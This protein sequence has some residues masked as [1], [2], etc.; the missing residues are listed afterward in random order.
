MSR[1]RQYEYEPGKEYGWLTVLG[2]APRDRFGHRMYQVRCRCG[3]EYPVQG[4]FL[5]KPEPK[6]S[7]CHLALPHNGRKLLSKPGDVI[8]GWT[9]LEEAGKNSHGAIL[10]KCRCSKCGG[11]SFHTRGDLTVRKGKGCQNCKP[12][13]HFRFRDG[14]AI[15]TL[16]SGVEFIVDAALAPRVSEFYWNI[17]SSKG[18]IHRTN[19]GM[20]KMMLHWFALGLDAGH[21][22]IIDHINRN[23]LDCRSENLRIVTSQQNAMNKSL[24]KNNTTGFVGVCFDNSKQNYIASIGFNDKKIYLGRS[25]DPVICAQRYN[26]ASELLFGEYAGH[27]NDVPEAD[28]EIKKYIYEKL[29]PYIASAIIARQPAVM[30]VTA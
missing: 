19:T 28:S 3:K 12:D 15:G 8:N 23:K 10:Y 11:V 2:E 29:S 14:A 9:I 5:R 6:C 22:E 26:Y 7:D 27:K 4:Q 13:Y 18:Y 16:P 20:P 30:P 21:G 17:E 24:S 1:P 25:Q